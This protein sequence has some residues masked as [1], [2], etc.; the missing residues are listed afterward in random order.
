MSQ[1]ISTNPFYLN[2]FKPSEGRIVSIRPPTKNEMFPYWRLEYSKNAKIN[3]GRRSR[4]DLP[5][6]LA[7]QGIEYQKEN[8]NCVHLV[9]LSEAIQCWFTSHAQY[10]D[11]HPIVPLEQVRLVHLANRY[12]GKALLSEMTHDVFENIKISLYR[13]LS[14]ENAAEIIRF[15]KEI[16]C[17]L[18]RNNVNLPCQTNKLKISCVVLRSIQPSLRE[19]LKN[20]SPSLYCILRLIEETGIDISYLKYIKRE[21]IHFVCTSGLCVGARISTFSVRQQEGKT[22]RRYIEYLDEVRCISLYGD[23]VDVL[24]QTKVDADG[25]LFPENIE[26][27]ASKALGRLLKEHEYPKTTFRKIKEQALIR[28]SSQSSISRYE[29][30][31]DKDID[32]IL[33]ETDVL[34]AWVEAEDIVCSEISEGCE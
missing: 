19:A 30:L 6:W 29:M 24:H 18:S 33:N 2:H 3:I 13:S 5:Q 10:Y 1:S 11:W 15:L 25:Y 8:P 28:L 34:L 20:T 4:E 23:I 17:W 22:V 27:T 21:H 16:L 32:I 12:L 9:N 7:A 26:S 31:S 14:E